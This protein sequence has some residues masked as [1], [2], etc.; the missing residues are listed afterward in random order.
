M[1]EA[2]YWYGKAFVKAFNKQ[3]D[4]DSD[5]IKIA[6]FTDAHAPAQDDEYHDAANGLT[7]VS[8]GNGYT[9]GGETL[10]SKTISYTDGTNIFA[11]D[12]AD[13]VWTFTATKTARYACIYDDTPESNKPLICFIDFGANKTVTDAGTLTVTFAAG[14]I[15]KTT[16]TDFA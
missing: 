15:A 10:A 3:I 9:T 16:I 4:Y 8:S 11:I 13:V 14:G 5:T 1:A 7:E 12:A 2:I 6:L